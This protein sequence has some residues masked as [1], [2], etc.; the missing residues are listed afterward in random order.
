VELGQFV[1]LG[2]VLIAISY[3]RRHSSYLRM[4][5]ATNVLLMSAGFLLVGFQIAG[6]LV[7]KG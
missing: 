3:W 2:S 7:S 5:R 1:A 4:A 6:F